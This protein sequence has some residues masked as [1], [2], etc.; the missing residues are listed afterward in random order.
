MNIMTR[1]EV[2]ACNAGPGCGTPGP[3]I[4]ASA[5]AL[6]LTVTAA[7]A[8]ADDLSRER[9]EYEQNTVDVVNAAGPSVVAVNLSLE[10]ER[11]T[12]P[13]DD[14]ET[15]AGGSGFVIDDEGRIITNFHV[16]A[17]LLD[18]SDDD[19]LELQEGASLT[20][21][22]LGSPDEEYDVRVT[23]ANPDIDLA[24]LT[25]EDPDAAP[26][27]PPIPIGDSDQ[28]EPGEKAIA[29]GNP[30]GLHS[31]V[32]AGIVSAVE[33]ERPGIAGI[34]IP[35]IQ[36]D[37]AIN[38][39]NSGG[40]LLNSSAQ[41]VGINNAILGDP[42][43]TFAGVGLA[44]PVNLL[45]DSLEELQAGG[46]SGFAAAAAQIPDKPRM[47]LEVALSVDD[48]P[49]EL[50]QELELPD[51]GV[52][53]TAVAPDGPADAAGIQGPDSAVSVSARDFPAGMDIITAINEEAVD[54]A[55]DIQRVI[56]EHG[57]GDIVVLDVWREGE[58]R[59]V[60]VELEVVQ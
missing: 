41:V 29:I 12:M 56:L 18:D 40:P 59:E 34:E 13:M 10:G 3:V 7:N 25:H 51:H 48:Y 55:V 49:Q 37:T 44:V 57:E 24:L 30:F 14:D 2:P 39:G 43:G 32:T 31:S 22:Y 6:A 19:A 1:L 11:V 5:L 26:D 16:V 42:T 45:A 50:Q 54:H 23:G 15:R 20:V 35:Y 60:E 21:S 38:P 33:R 4:A 28:V 46:L 9:L 58:A 47:G 52:V 53:V 17:S 8:S 27:V 36:T